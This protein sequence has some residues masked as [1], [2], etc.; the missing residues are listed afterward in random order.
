MT[1]MKKSNLPEN[2]F[3][4]QMA[5]WGFAIQGD[6]LEVSALISEGVNALTDVWD[7]TKKDLADTYMARDGSWI[8]VPDWFALRWLRASIREKAL[9]GEA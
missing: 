8:P 6:G 5:I 4:F 1:S 9:R 2:D 3:D 7:R